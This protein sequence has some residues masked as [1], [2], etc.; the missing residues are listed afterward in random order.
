MI[1]SNNNT[2]SIFLVDGYN[3]FI[4]CYMAYPTMNNNGEPIGGAIGFIKK[5]AELS[6]IFFPKAIYIAWEGGGSSR[7]RS[8]RSTY[9]DKRVPE[10]LNRYY[11]DD[12]PDT[13]ENQLDQLKLLIK[14]L[15]YLPCYQLYVENCEGDDV[16]AFLSKNNFIYENKI[17]ISSDKDLYQLVDNKTDIWDLYKKKLITTENIFEEF[18]VYPNNFSILKTICGDRTDNIQGIKGLGFK[19]ALKMFPMLSQKEDILLSDIISYAASNKDKSK[20]YNSCFESKEF[21][22]E[23]LQLVDLTGLKLSHNQVQKLNNV[24]DNFIPKLDIY[25][26]KILFHNNSINTDINLIELL[27]KLSYIKNKNV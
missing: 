4:R 24:I 14:I 25:N 17:I 2:N 12:I 10:R 20:I 11:K 27:T 3:L 23:N 15:K 13:V 9:K 21:L 6:S 22:K 5:I 26:L 18:K 1:N 16:I 19:N 7:R 8:I